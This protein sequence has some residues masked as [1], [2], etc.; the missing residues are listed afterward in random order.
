ML[1]RKKYNW[2]EPFIELK[3]TKFLDLT[4]KLKGQQQI[5]ITCEETVIIAEKKTSC[6]KHSKCNM[7]LSKTQTIRTI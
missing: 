3:Q 2:S 6:F 4:I 1:N 5:T 7:T